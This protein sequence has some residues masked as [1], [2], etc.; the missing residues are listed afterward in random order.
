MAIPKRGKAKSKKP[1]ADAAGDPLAA[2]VRTQMPGWKL[3]PSSTGAD[4]LSAA[5]DSREAQKGVDIDTLRKKFLK[6]QAKTADA[7]PT[8]AR[9]RAAAPVETFKI[10]PEGGG[11]TQVAERRNGT[12]RI[13]SG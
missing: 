5:G 2:A 3:V 7:A 12:I 11:P 4:A 8:A 13:V 10:E 1:A 6:G 9:A